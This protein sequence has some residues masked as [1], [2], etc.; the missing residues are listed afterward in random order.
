MITY[1][2][3]DPTFIKWPK[4]VKAKTEFQALMKAKKVPRFKKTKIKIKKRR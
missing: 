2:A 1:I 3:F 4:E